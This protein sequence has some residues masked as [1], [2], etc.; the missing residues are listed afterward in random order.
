MIDEIKKIEE[1][2]RR[3]TKLL[4]EIPVNIKEQKKSLINN[5]LNTELDIL[6][7]KI[8][9]DG[10]IR[11]FIFDVHIIK[12]CN[13]MSQY[14]VANENGEENIFKE[15]LSKIGIKR[16]QLED[17]TNMYY[18]TDRQFLEYY[19]YNSIRVYSRYFDGYEC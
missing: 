5:S 3:Q 16:I 14:C 17:K 11:L 6:H 9:Y 8:K 15:K 2:I 1:L 13:D 7:S 19:N 18:I 12:L 4:D 10:K